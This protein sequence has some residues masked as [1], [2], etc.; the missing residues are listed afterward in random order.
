[1]TV[2]DFRRSAVRNLSRSKL[3][4]D[5]AMKLTGHKTR[6]VYSRY[7]ITNF[8]DLQDAVARLAGDSDLATGKVSGKVRSGLAGKALA[9]DG[10]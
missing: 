10:N 6:A 5:V 7:N 3:T 9:A 8:S 2:H 1:M 4:D